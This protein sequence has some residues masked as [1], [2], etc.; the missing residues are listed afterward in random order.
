M[1]EEMQSII[2]N[3]DTSWPKDYI[4]RYLYVKLAPFFQRDLSYFLASDEEKYR[5]YQQGFV[6]NG[7]YIVCSTLADFYVNIFKQF[8]INAKKIAANSARVPLFAL[9]AEGEAGTIYMDPLGDLFNNQY[10]LNTTEFAV[11]PHYQ[12]LKN[13][14]PELISWSKDYIQMIDQ[15]LGLYPNNQTL[16]P[17]FNQLHNEITNRSFLREFFQIDT[18]DRLELF[19]KRMNFANDH[20]INLGQVR[21]PFERIKLYFFLERIL[22]FKT[23]KKAISINLNLSTDTPKCNIGYCLNDSGKPDIMLQE[24]SNDNEYTL[25][26]VL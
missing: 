16:T 1:C 3:V 6:N 22:F 12:T 18:S 7:F 9:V 25:K 21:G 19:L 14:Y 4:I 15:N 26:R 2:N 24:E 11:V 13:N 5:I 17:F 23:D 20:L 10:G 8:G